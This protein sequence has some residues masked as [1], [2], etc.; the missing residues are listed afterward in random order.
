MKPTKNED[1]D[2]FNQQADDQKQQENY[3]TRNIDHIPAS[4][5]DKLYRKRLTEEEKQRVDDMFKKFLGTH[6]YH[7]F[8]KE[9]KAS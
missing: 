2:D 3:F 8:T 5:Y 4:H 9:V 1:S 6:K 7:N